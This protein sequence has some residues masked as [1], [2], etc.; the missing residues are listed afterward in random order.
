MQIDQKKLVEEAMQGDEAAFERLIKAKR[1][2]ILYLSIRMGSSEDGE[3]IAQEV[4]IHAYRDL[5]KLNDPEKFNAW[6][7]G[8][9]RNAS[10][11]MAKKKN[12]SKAV[13]VDPYEGEF[14]NIEES[15]EEFLPAE[16]LE[17]SEKQSEIM[18]A[19]E[20]L[21]LT[22]RECLLLF[23]YEGL[24]YREIS[25]ALDTSTK[26]VANNLIQAK[27]LLKKKI[28][29]A[30]IIQPTQR[31]TAHSAVPVLTL[32]FREDSS[33]I[34]TAEMHS[35]FDENLR[36]IANL[37]P[38]HLAAF[39]EGGSTLAPFS[40]LAAEPVTAVVGV[41]ASAAIGGGIAK[42]VAG[43]VLAVSLIGGG[44]ALSQ[45]PGFLNP[46]GPGQGEASEPPVQVAPEE[47]IPAITGQPAVEPT[48]ENNPINETITLT[49]G[50][51]IGAQA[52]AMLDAYEAQG[53]ASGPWNAFV[54]S[55]GASLIYE[56]KELDGTSYRM[57]ILDNG[58]MRLLLYEMDPNNGSVRILYEFGS[59]TEL[60]IP[61]MMEMIMYFE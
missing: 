44:Y 54:S 41:G 16:C 13:L 23:Y 14:A 53:A 31:N 1:K 29:E 18:Q 2:D 46:A 35:R 26:N 60:L 5:H 39:K 24:S 51:M 10:L 42:A 37:A 58:E 15:R 17:N 56:S 49:V 34:I 30:G 22:N 25:L 3:D 38:E 32:I 50:N 28:E 12:K 48:V 6:L 9:V 21:P 4:L 43:A 47:E 33:S 36:N 7:F 40:T 52:A 27:Y 11:N 19:I 20:E 57:Y 45:N 8:I 55:I 59:P 61:R